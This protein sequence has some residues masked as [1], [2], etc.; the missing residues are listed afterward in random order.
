MDINADEILLPDWVP[1]SIFFH[2]LLSVLLV[3]VLF[4]IVFS[5]CVCVC[6]F[7]LQFAINPIFKCVHSLKSW[8]EI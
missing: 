8:H 5:V 2:L 4:V 1:G 7:M 6:Y 3:F